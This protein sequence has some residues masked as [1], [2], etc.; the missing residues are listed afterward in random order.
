MSRSLWR[1]HEIKYTDH[2]WRF[3][4]TKEL[5]VGS[6][7]T[8]GHCNNPKTPDGYDACIGTLPG[9]INAC[10]GHGVIQEAYVQFSL[11]KTIRG[12]EAIEFIKQ[13]H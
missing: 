11:E 1:G 6:D 8:C 3:V 7:R 5:T 12:S 10:C 4:D 2:E 9:V 13:N